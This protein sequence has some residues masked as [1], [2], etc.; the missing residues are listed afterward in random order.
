MVVN[1]VGPYNN[2]VETYEFYSLP[3]C[4]PQELKSH[5]QDLGEVNGIEAAGRAANWARAG[6]RRRPQDYLSVRHPF[7]R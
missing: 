7:R 2:P 5:K 3:F 1:N 4:A 6:P